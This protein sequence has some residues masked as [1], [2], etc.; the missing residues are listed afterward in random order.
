MGL[1]EDIAPY[2]EPKTQG[3]SNGKNPGDHSCDNSLLFSSEYIV[4]MK[5]TGE[6][7]FLP[8]LAWFD[9]FIEKFQTPEGMLNRYPDSKDYEAQ[10]DYIGVV[11]ACYSICNEYPKKLYAYAKKNW[12]ML[13]NVEPGR[14]R[15]DNLFF[16]FPDFRPFLKAAAGEKLNWFDAFC[17]MTAYLYSIAKAKPDD[18]DDKILLWLKSQVFR[19]KNPL[20]DKVLNYW[21]AHWLTQLPGGMEQVFSGYF[22]P[23]HPFVKYARTDFL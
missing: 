9:A 17:A 22:G 15:I 13:N 7:A 1:F 2:R 12:Y 4:L 16:R 3:I 10:D 8:E 11:T 14:F 23:T 21:A 18:W 6:P 5:R 19:Y 20:L